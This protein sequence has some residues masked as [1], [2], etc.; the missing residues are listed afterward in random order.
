MDD[1]LNGRKKRK[2]ENT[3]PWQWKK[4]RNYL[5]AK[6]QRKR[7]VTKWKNKQ[8]THIQVYAIEMSSKMKEDKDRVLSN[9]M[10]WI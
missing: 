6:K 9:L 4:K 2:M 7:P 3:N 1:E 5:E 10:N 8:T